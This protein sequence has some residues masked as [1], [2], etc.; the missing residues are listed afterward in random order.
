MR[1]AMGALLLL[2]LP[3]AVAATTTTGFT[4]VPSTHPNYGAIMDLKERGIISGYPD[5]TFKPDQMVNRVEALKI[6]LLGASIAV[7]DNTGTGGF[8][9]TAATEWY[10]KYL[11]KAKELGIVSGYPD[12]TFKPTQTVNLV[13]N[14]K[15]LINTS[16]IDITNVTVNED[17][18]SDTPKTEWYAKDVEYAKELQWIT[19]DQNNMV[20][21][22]QGMTRGKLAQLLYNAIHNTANNSTQQQTQQTQQNQNPSPSTTPAPAD[23]NVSIKNFA[24]NKASMTIAQ[25]T[26]VAWT[27]NDATSHTVTSDDGTSFNSGPIAPGQTFSY[28]FNTLGTF[29][30][31][32]SIHPTMTGSIVVKNPIEVPT[33]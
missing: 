28:T 17:S 16:K 29:T 15:M 5:G 33:I 32:C 1:I 23:L 27:N 7:P 24:F 12:G 30:Y 20:Y 21:P 2:A 22:A 14:L 9:D 19:P 31:H 18:F 11:L 10:A 26:K 4:D 25:G 13:E 3:M 6:I 8:K